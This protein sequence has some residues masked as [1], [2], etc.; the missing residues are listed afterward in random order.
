VDVAVKGPKGRQYVIWLHDIAY[1]ENFAYNLISFRKLSRRGYWWDTRPNQNCLKRADNTVF[2]YLTDKFDQ[3]VLED[4][5]KDLSWASFFTRRNKFNSYT[6]RRPQ[7]ALARV[8]H[9]R[10]SHPGPLAIQH[11]VNC[12]QGVRIKG[13]TTVQCDRC[14]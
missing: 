2:A 7:W 13:P 5:P 4:I 10:L 11:L 9:L 3:F 14:G 12:S 6:N 8:W 1:C